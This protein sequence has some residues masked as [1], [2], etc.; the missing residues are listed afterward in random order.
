MSVWSSNLC[1][2][3]HVT[4]VRSKWTRSLRILPVDEVFFKWKGRRSSNLHCG[5]W[6]QSYERFTHFN[7]VLYLTVNAPVEICS[8]P[9][10][11]Q[12]FSTIQTVVGLGI[13]PST[14]STPSIGWQDVSFPAGMGPGWFAGQHAAVDRFAATWRI[15]HL[16]MKCLKN[17]RPA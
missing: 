15:S 16:T 4:C 13:L 11:L 5:T 12:G 1:K 7:L 2:M 17:V 14:G 6:A 10:Y 8:L 3:S 9:H